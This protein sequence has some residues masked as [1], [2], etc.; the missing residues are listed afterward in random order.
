MNIRSMTRCALC[1]AL[2]ALCA[3]IALPAG[4]IAFT[5]QTLGLFLTLGLLGGKRGTVAIC[6]YLMLGAVGL[7]VFSGFQGGI[8]ILLGAS[9]GYILGFLAAA[10]A[11]WGVTA[12]FP[13]ALLPAMILGQ[14]ICYAFGT[15]WFQLVYLES[16]TSLALGAVVAKCVLPY[17]FPDA[18]KLILAWFLLRRMRIMNPPGT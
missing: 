2:M 3:W 15:L 9:G 16:G 11:Y 8:G 5:L 14:L 18:V 17:L 6:I 7:P 1:A 13:K 4:D 10:L 12:L